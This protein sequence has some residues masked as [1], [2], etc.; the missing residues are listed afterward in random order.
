MNNQVVKKLR[1]L[2]R[3]IAR[4]EMEIYQSMPLWARLKVAY[5]I[6]FKC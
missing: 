3:K 5:R 4:R 2:T 1:Q 6:V